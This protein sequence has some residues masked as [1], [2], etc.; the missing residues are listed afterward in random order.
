[1]RFHLAASNLMLLFFK[2]ATVVAVLYTRRVITCALWVCVRLKGIE[3]G[4]FSSFIKL[5]LARVE[6]IY[7][8]E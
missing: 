3:E 5:V 2:V 8:G 7:F 1:M 4:L 6:H